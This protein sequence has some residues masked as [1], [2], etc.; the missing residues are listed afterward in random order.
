MASL[1][2]LPPKV[3]NLL[4]LKDK[5]KAFFFDMDGVYVII[6]T[7]DTKLKLIFNSGMAITKYKTQSIPTKS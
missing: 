4:E 5:Y 7:I 1:H 6:S 2:Q 3:K